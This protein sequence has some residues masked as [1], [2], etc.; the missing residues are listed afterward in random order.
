MEV[1]VVRVSEKIFANALKL[2]Q[3][4]RLSVLQRPPLHLQ[5]P[6]THYKV[7]YTSPLIKNSF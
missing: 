6:R 2:F 5:V 1:S 3:K 4:N 7:K